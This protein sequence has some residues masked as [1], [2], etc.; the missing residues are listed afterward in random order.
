MLI[1]VVLIGSFAV[2]FYVKKNDDIKGVSTSSLEGKSPGI[3]VSV[4]S[5]AP[6]WDLMAYLCSSV[7]ACLISLSSGKR[8]ST[9]SSGSTELKDVEL[10]YSKDW[11]S[12]PYLKIFARP[13]WL[14]G[15][16]SFRIVTVGDVPDTLAEKIPVGKSFQ[17]V[18]LVPTIEIAETFYKSATFSDR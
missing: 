12:Y 9:V 18:L 6:S 8:L 3:S 11:E 10:S 15:S 5:D 4:I 14:L 2:F 16:T 13:S 1:V 17:D 7:E